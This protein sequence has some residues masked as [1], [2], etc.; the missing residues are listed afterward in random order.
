[1]SVAEF[2]G[3]APHPRPLSRKGRGERKVEFVPSHPWGRGWQRATMDVTATAKCG[4]Q[5][6][7]VAPG[8]RVHAFLYYAKL[9]RRAGAEFVRGAGADLSFQVCVT[10]I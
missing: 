1:M 8:E 4:S 9:T 7:S 3:M 2:G 6:S 10:L 5:G